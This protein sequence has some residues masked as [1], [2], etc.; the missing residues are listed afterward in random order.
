MPGSWFLCSVSFLVLDAVLNLERE[1]S[2]TNKTHRMVINVEVLLITMC[3][4]KKTVLKNALFLLEFY[5][6]FTY[7]QLDPTSMEMNSESPILF[8][9]G[10][11]GPWQWKSSLLKA[12]NGYSKVPLSKVNKEAP[13]LKRSMF[14]LNTI[15]QILSCKVQSMQDFHTGKRKSGQPASCRGLG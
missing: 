7:T 15:V 3:F 9:K 4:I 2:A 10:R 12:L 6:L 1:V 14:I 13:S 11:H 8:H 5:R